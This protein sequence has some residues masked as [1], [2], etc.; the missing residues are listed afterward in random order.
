MPPRDF[1]GDE[2]GLPQ[3]SRRS[4][5]FLQPPNMQDPDGVRAA[6]HRPIQWDAVDETAVEKVFVADSHRRESPRQRARRKYRLNQ[7]PTVEPVFTST[8]DAGRHALERHGE[9]RKRLRRQALAQQPTKRAVAMQRSPAV[10]EAGEPAD[11]RTVEHAVPT[12]RLPD[13]Q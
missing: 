12:K 13:R 9:I 7:L 6:C 10:D 5:V 8:L 3:E 11:Q 2:R 4:E 1:E